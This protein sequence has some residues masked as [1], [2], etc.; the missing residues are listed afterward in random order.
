MSSE[1]PPPARKPGRPRKDATR[2]PARELLLQAAITRIAVHGTTDAN[3]RDVCS[4]AGVTFAMVNYNFG[5]WNGLIA[6]AASVVYVDYVEGLWAQVQIA[7]REPEA[8]L[9]A[10]L[11][12]QLAWAQRMP[13]WGAVFNYPFSA[14]KATEILREK[15]GSVT[16]GYFQLNLARLEQLTID[17][18]ENKVTEFDYNTDNFPR[19]ELLADRLA[20]ARSTMV[21]WT[22]LGMGVW[23]GRGAT[24][25]TQ[26]P[27]VQEFQSFLFEFAVEQSIA[28]I[29]ADQGK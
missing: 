3:A 22:S 7:D 27:E 29:R 28:D 14:R 16:S 20:A 9:R 25:E 6:E 21:G 8:R 1:T 17:V 26:L 15:F 4:D 10:F 24:L 11:N 12:A 23:A 2:I 19:E 18:R 13:G 5:S